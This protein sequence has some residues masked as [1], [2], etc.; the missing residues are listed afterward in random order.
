MANNNQNNKQGNVLSEEDKEKAAELKKQAEELGLDLVNKEALSSILDKL[1][2]L[3]EKVNE[4]ADSNRLEQFD[5]KKRGR[6]AIERYVRLNVRDI[7]EG[8]I[9]KQKVL[10]GWKTIIDRVEK[11]SN[12][13]VWSET[14][15]VE[16]TYE[17][18]TKEQMSYMDFAQN[19]H[20][21]NAVI[22]KRERQEPILDDTVE[23]IDGN[24]LI[25]ESPGEEFITVKR[26]DNGKEYRLNSSFIN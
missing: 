23:D 19:T 10:V 17:D 3:E 7:K 18:G 5:R 6:A 15:I 14:Q 12:T 9:S 1:K 22:I 26:S 11:N 25:V 8:D 2:D 16:V 13:G 20:F 21:V 4:T 24:P